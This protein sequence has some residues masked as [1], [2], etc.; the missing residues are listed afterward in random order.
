MKER[1][2]DKEL[3]FVL[4]HYE[5]N[6]FDPDK[7]IRRI[8][9]AGPR[10][11]YR[12]IAVAASVLCLTV[13]AATWVWQTA[14]PSASPADVPAVTAVAT[15]DTVQVSG[16]FHFD[17]TPLPEVLRALGH[18]YGVQLAASDTTRCLTGDFSGETLGEILAMIENVLDV[19][20]SQNGNPD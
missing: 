13:M 7:A 4:Q 18:H 20:I 3:D 15:P 6:R 1:E 11:R 9:P 14:W 5:E 2:N 8:Q 16:S 12:W 17:A 19:T 10:R